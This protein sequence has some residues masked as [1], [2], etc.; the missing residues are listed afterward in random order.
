MTL[1]LSPAMSAFGHG[2]GQVTGKVARA[3]EPA[4]VRLDGLVV[5]PLLSS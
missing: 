3:E 5:L 2:S 4:R 1:G